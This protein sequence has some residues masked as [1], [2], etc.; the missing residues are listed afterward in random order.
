MTS[1][2]N[3]GA[4]LISDA[5]IGLPYDFLERALTHQS[6]LEDVILPSQYIKINQLEADDEKRFVSFSCDVFE[7][8]RN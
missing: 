5:E 8:L 2:N 3:E 6:I 4:T 1:S 7:Y